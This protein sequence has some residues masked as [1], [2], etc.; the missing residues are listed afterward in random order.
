MALEILMTKYLY[1]NSKPKQSTG[2]AGAVDF[3]KESNELRKGGPEW[4]FHSNA[5]H[6]FFDTFPT[7]DELRKE[8]I[9]PIE[10]ALLRAPEVVL[11]NTVF[12]RTAPHLPLCWLTT[13]ESFCKGC[14]E[15]WFHG[16]LSSKK[17]FVLERS[18]EGSSL[19]VPS[20]G[21]QC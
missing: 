8:I 21:V 11:N 20:T 9:P 4:D 6:D 19:V 12:Q 18:S 14:S 2:Y 3:V 7:L 15:R 17:G 5:L 13:L 16:V 1:Y 10:K